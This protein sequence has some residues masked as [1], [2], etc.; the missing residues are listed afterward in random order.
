MD[1]VQQSVDG[2]NPNN[3]IALKV[4]ELNKD[5][6]ATLN[7]LRKQNAER[8]KKE[9]LEND[10]SESAFQKMDN[11]IIYNSKTKIILIEL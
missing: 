9:K 3:N 4:Y 6:S 7:E 10:K 5:Y 11:R 8:Q 1:R 2:A